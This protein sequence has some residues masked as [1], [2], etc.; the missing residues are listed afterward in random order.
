MMYEIRKL[1]INTCEKA[2]LIAKPKK[3][4]EENRY[5][6]RRSCS[7]RTKKLLEM[8][9]SPLRGLYLSINILYILI[10]LLSCI[11]IT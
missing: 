6:V 9:R 11:T 10:F 1:E 3:Y 4:R 7:D 8:P 2:L 5:Q